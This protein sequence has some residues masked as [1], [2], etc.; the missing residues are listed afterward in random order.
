MAAGG[1]AK[2][3]CKQ[4]KTPY[5]EHAQFASTGCPGISDLGRLLL[6][7]TESCLDCV[8]IKRGGGYGAVLAAPVGLN[9]TQPKAGIPDLSYAHLEFKYGRSSLVDTHMAVFAATLTACKV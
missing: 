2:P 8:Q 1:G 7:G 5:R 4:Q 9:D 6:S 3:P